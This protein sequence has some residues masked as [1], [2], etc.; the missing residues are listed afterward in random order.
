MNDRIDVHEPS[1]RR[2]RK[3]R[4]SGL[5]RRSNNL[6]FEL[7]VLSH[8]VWIHVTLTADRVTEIGDLVEWD[9][10]GSLYTLVHQH[11]GHEAGISNEAIHKSR[12]EYIHIIGP[13]VVT[14]GPDDLNILS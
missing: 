14:Q 5:D 4:V 2:Y 12:A 6:P 9:K 3:N 13:P 10:D 1:H 7:P 11:R 8:G